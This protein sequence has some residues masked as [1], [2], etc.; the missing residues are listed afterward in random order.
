MFLQVESEVDFLS[1]LGCDDS[2]LVKVVSVFGNTGDGKSHTLNNTFFG[3]REV[4]KTSAEQVSC[5]IGAWGAFDPVH[6]AIVVDTEGMLGVT[7]NPNQRTRLLLK[8]LAISDVVIYRTKA[9]RLHTDMFQFLGDAS[10]AYLKHFSEELRAAS[11]RNKMDLPLSNLGPAV[12][13][14]HETYHTE[15]LGKG[16]NIFQELDSAFIANKEMRVLLTLYQRNM[17]L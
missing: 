11:K 17:A 5:T 8:V 10:K 4:F 3:G 16:N 1:K 13:I 12:V 6:N 9:D 2:T 14:F 7:S 15:V